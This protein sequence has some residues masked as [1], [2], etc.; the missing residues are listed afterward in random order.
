MKPHYL[1]PSFPKSASLPLPILV[2]RKPFTKQ[3]QRN[4]LWLLPSPIFISSHHQFPAKWLPLCLFFSSY[5]QFYSLVEVNSFLLAYDSVHLLFFKLYFFHL[6]HFL[7]AKLI[8]FNPCLKPFQ[9]T[10]HYLKLSP[11]LV[12]RCHNISGFNFYGNFS[13][14]TC[15]LYLLSPLIVLFFFFFRISSL[16]SS[17]FLY[18]FSFCKAATTIH[19]LITPT[20][21]STPPISHQGSKSI[22]LS[23][24]WAHDFSHKTHSYGWSFCLHNATSFQLP[25]H[26]ENVN[27]PHCTVPERN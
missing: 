21:L 10:I 4:Q 2:N 12:F 7:K 27:P 19:M 22:F 5:P 24:Y 11:H 13:L 9:L 17:F 1:F 14:L 15:W 18:I 25:K 26:K 6:V 8:I 20:Y 3:K 16:C 23:T